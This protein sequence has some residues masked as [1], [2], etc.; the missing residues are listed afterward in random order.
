MSQEWTFQNFSAIQIL[1][2]INFGH[3][4]ALKTAVLNVLAALNF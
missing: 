1:R 3:L 2:E 4:K